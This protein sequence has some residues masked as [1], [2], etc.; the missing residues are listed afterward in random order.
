MAINGDDLN[1]DHKEGTAEGTT[2]KEI[3]QSTGDSETGD[4]NDNDNDSELWGDN[5]GPVKPPINNDQTENGCVNDERSC[6]NT[7]IRQEAFIEW[8]TPIKGTRTCDGTN[9]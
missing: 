8:Q 3:R 7:R 2:V 4:E 6:I 9:Y 5:R 1:D